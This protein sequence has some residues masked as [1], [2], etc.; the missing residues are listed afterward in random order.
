MARLFFVIDVKTATRFPP[1]IPSHHHFMLNGAWTKRRIFKKRSVKRLCCGEID[2]VPDQIHQL[3]WT[4][5][6]ITRQSHNAIDGFNRRVPVT[7]YSQRLVV[8]RTGHPVNDKAW[9]VFCPGR[10]FAY[11]AH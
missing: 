7:Q 2:V 3:K 6:E 4:H 8:E 5:A 11:P 10:G 9:S 1:E